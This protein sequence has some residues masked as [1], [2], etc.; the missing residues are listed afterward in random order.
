MSLRANT[1]ICY[2]LL[3]P[4][5]LLAGCLSS[6]E[7]TGEPGRRDPDQPTEQFFDYQMVETSNG[8]KQ[9]VLVSSEMRKYSE[10]EDV[11]LTTVEMEFYREGEHFSTLTADSGKAHLQTRD[12]HTWGNVVVVTDDGRRLETEE[13]F[14]SNETQLIHN[15]VYNVFTKELDVV[16]GIGL[17]ATPD[18]EYIEIKQRVEAEVGDDTSTLGSA[19]TTESD[20]H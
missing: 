19:G 1:L 12:I 15:E 8:I 4:V 14:F 11:Q 18:L 13:L 16:T 3:L 6:E 5:L 7:S 2:L 17:E 9:W 10:Q 20:P